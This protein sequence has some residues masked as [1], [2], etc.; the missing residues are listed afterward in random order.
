MNDLA[1]GVSVEIPSDVFFATVFGVIALAFVGVGV[2]LVVQLSRT[3]RPRHRMR[4]VESLSRSVNLAIPVDLR[5][6]LA[7][8]VAVRKRGALIGSLIALPIIPLML[9]PWADPPPSFGS[10]TSIIG[11]AVVLCSTTMGAVVGGLFGRRSPHPAQRTARLTPLSYSDLIAPVERSLV[12]LCVIG[13]VALPGLL[14]LATAAPWVNRGLAEDGNFPVL[15]AAGLICVGFALALPRIGRRLVSARA[16]PGD[17]AALAWSDA[18]AAR[19]LRDI[20]Y[21]I[22]S[23]SGMSALTATIWAGAALP[24]EWNTGIGMLGTVGS[25]VGLGA[26]IL[27]IVVVSARKPERHVQRTL[28]PQY[29]RSAE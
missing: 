20:A 6:P 8:A 18:L 11:I 2:A 25:Y 4:A 10:A 9:R 29:A 13:G 7:H 22:A 17:E 28:W 1:T 5:E 23:V 21:L 24:R 15:L 26:I 19:T 16:I 12:M 3:W 14:T 27:A